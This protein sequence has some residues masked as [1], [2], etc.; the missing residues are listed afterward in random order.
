MSEV[1]VEVLTAQL[2]QAV[3]VELVGHS[4][5][6]L[7]VLRRQLGG[8]RVREVDDL[9]RSFRRKSWDGHFPLLCA[10]RLFKHYQKHHQCLSILV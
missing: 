8:A 3:H 6:D 9:A 5:E 4:R 1:L 10:E 2:E 7:D